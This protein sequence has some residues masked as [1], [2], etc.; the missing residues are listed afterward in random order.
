ML[1]PSRLR[2]EQFAQLSQQDR[3]SLLATVSHTL[4]LEP[5]TDLIRQ[6]DRPTACYLVLDGMMC[7]YKNLQG[8]RRQILGFHLAGDFCDL[9]GPV[10]GR[11]D[12]NVASLS[13]AKLAVIPTP[14][15]FRLLEQ[16][17]QIGHALWK[18]TIADAAIAREW[19]ANVGGRSAYERIAHLLCEMGRRIEAAGLAQDGAFDWPIRH[20]DLA[21]AMALS[22]VHVSQV[23]QR[24]SNEGLVKGEEG[25][26]QL[27]DWPGLEAAGQFRSHYLFLANTAVAEPLPS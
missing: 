4:E 19:I 6:D 11:M 25:R 24:L 26:L 20:Q 13:A 16:R 23:F 9:N 10:M 5:N 18:E 17:P 22:S 15:L 27:L 3:Q 21:E 2:L 7:R 14:A 8:G 12:H 1:L